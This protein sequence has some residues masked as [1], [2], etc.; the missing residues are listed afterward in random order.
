M[1]PSSSY[2]TGDGCVARMSGEFISVGEVLQLAVI[3][4]FNRNVDIA[5]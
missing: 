5:L 3:A 4:A 1:N 2:S